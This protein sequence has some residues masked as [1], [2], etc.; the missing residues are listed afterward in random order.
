MDSTTLAKLKVGLSIAPEDTS[1]DAWLALKYD[2]VLALMRNRTGS[3]LSPVRRYRDVFHGAR[4]WVDRWNEG[5]TPKHGPITV[6]E[7]CTVNGNVID[8]TTLAVT[9]DNRISFYAVPGAYCA[10]VELIYLAGYPELPEDL[11]DVMLQLLAQLIQ[12]L[13]N[14]GGIVPSRISLIDVGTLEFK[15]ADSFTDLLGPYGAILEPYVAHVMVGAP[16]IV[17]SYDLGEAG[18]TPPPD[19]VTTYHYIGDNGSGAYT[20]PVFDSISNSAPTVWNAM[21][22]DGYAN[23]HMV[24]AG[25]AA[26]WDT[27]GDDRLFSDQWV[28]SIPDATLLDSLGA[29]HEFGLVVHTTTGT[30]RNVLLRYVNTTEEPVP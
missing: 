19:T 29:A 1:R 24:Q 4:F 5:L 2:S 3:M 6:I 11:F 16:L 25:V 7:S 8:P 28:T 30:N 27:Q 21:V 18:P 12:G 17:E 13:A 26:D 14:M 10:E 22:A 23:T 9:T 20:A 15:G